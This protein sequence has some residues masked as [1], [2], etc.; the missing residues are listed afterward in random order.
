MVAAKTHA[1]PL[2]QP[3]PAIGKKLHYLTTLGSLMHGRVF[4]HFEDAAKAD[5]RQLNRLSQRMEALLLESFS[6]YLA[7]HPSS[8]FSVALFK[9]LTA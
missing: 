7:W 5:L 8:R 6:R 1:H 4:Y 2:P 3:A 9:A